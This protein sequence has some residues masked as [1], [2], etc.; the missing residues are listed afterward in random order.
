VPTSWSERT[1]PFIG[2]RERTIEIPTA[3]DFAILLWGTIPV[4]MSGIVTGQ[5]A[6]SFTERS[7][8]AT[9]HTER[10]VGSTSWTERT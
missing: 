3:G 2:T 7:V 8:S 10:S 4:R 1:A 6:T 9:S 5:P